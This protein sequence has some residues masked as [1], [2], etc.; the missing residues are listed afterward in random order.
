MRG[1]IDSVYQRWAAVELQLVLDYVY[2]ET[3]P[4]LHAKRFEPLDFSV[5]PNPRERVESA[6]DFSTLIPK[7]KGEQLRRR[8]VAREGGYRPT[9]PIEVHLDGTSESALLAM[10]GED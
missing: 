9:R 10:G 2:F 1:V 4:M 8:L 7:E 3:Q 5:I 6:R